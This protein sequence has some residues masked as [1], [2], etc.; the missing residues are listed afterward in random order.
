MPDVRPEIGAAPGPLLDRRT[1][2]YLLA[3]LGLVVLVYLRALPGEFVWDDHTFFLE[4]DVLPNLK[5]WDLGRIFLYPTSY[6]GENLPLTELLFVIEYN[7][8]GEYTPAYHAVSLLL[9]VLVGIALFRLVSALYQDLEA[10]RAHTPQERSE[11]RRSILVVLLLF[12]IH[13]IHV[14]V[15]A[16]ITGQQHLLYSLFAFLAIERFSHVFRS[17][18]LPVRRG[19]LPAVA[20]YYLSILAKYQGVSTAVFVPLLWLLVF[21]RRGDDPWKALG[22]WIGLNTPVLLWILWSTQDYRGL[23]Q[24]QL[25]LWEAI[26]RAVRILGAHLILVFKPYPLSFGYPFEHAWSPDPA[27]F[28]GTAFLAALAWLLLFRRRSPATMGLL[29]AL[30]YLLPMLGI[31]MEVSNATV[32]DRYVFVSLLGLCMVFERILARCRLRGEPGRWLSRGVV[33]AVVLGLAALTLAYIPKFGSNTASLEHSYRHFP[34]WARAAFD[35]GYALI[36]EGRLDEAIALAESEPTYE[37]PAWVRDY[38]RGWI[39]LERGDHARAIAHLK[40][41]SAIIQRGG[42]FPFTGVPL[43]RAYLRA[44]DR[45]R[46][47]RELHLVLNARIQNPLEQYRAKALLEKIRSGED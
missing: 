26:P 30:A 19:L 38:L 4:N 29:I 14:E 43:A 36:E 15:V 47:E 3:L 5:P 33:A 11:Q 25:A 35:Y 23:D 45:Y 13:P 9:Y 42:Y 24:A 31:L 10:T 1:R 44:G 34:G 12:M 20:C 46:A 28:A 40:R 2:R 39:H 21:R 16:Y 27:F 22:F 6:W 32:Y 41:A 7:L 37:H 18:A 8:F 17:R